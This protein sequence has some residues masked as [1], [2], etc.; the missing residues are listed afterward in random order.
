M[1]IRFGLLT[2]SDRSSRGER[3]DLSGPALEQVL[4]TQGWTVIRKA[5]L[6]DDLDSLRHSLAEWA[7]S[8]RMDVILTTGGTGFGPRDVTPEATRDVIEREAP[9]LAEAMRLES[10]RVTQHAMLS[11]AV[12][13]IRS[14]TLIINLPGSPKGAVENLQVVLPVLA[15]AVELLKDEP[16][17]EQHH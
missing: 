17:A 13:G 12:A 9:G 11:R 7:D 1:E 6:P 15:H 14:R 16:D 5:V 8:G 4:V 2:A 10:L 3:P